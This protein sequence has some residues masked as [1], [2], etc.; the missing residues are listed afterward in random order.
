MSTG[1]GQSDSSLLDVEQREERTSMASSGLAMAKN[2]TWFLAL[3][4]ARESGGHVMK[5]LL[6]PCLCKINGS[7]WP[8]AHGVMR[9]SNLPNSFG[10]EFQL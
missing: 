8:L 9:P 1:W 10:E 2:Y 6:H 5:L 3:I 4:G 7:N